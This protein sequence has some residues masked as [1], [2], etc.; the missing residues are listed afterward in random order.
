MEEFIAN[1]NVEHKPHIFAIAAQAFRAA[2]T[3]MLNGIPVSSPNQAFIISGESGSGKTESTKL[4]LQ[5]ISEASG[6]LGSASSGMHSYILSVNPLLEAFGNA[7][8]VRNDNSSR[9]GKW[10]EIH[11]KKGAT[12]KPKMVGAV[13]INYLLEKS[14]V[15]SVGPGE[16]GYHIF[17]QLCSACAK[18]PVLN[19]KYQLDHPSKF[20]FLNGSNVFSLPHLSD[21]KEFEN[22]LSAMELIKFTPEEIDGILQI[23]A[24]IL[25]AGNIVIKG[26][27]TDAGV[28]AFI[29]NEAQ[30][31]KT[32][33]ILEVP[34]EILKR[35]ILSK[36]FGIG[37]LAL[38]NLRP[39]EAIAMRNS[40][41]TGLYAK[42]FDWLVHKAN[43]QLASSELSS[44]KTQK[45]MYIGV[46]DIFGFEIFE[47]NSFEQFW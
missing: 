41:C 2:T 39:E 21:D 1:N 12:V 6:G 22:T 35:V 29:E 43:K 19:E 10:M 15:I 26:R 31:Q 13:I 36:E 34:V 45:D 32:A 3:G 8:T 5:Y 9:F 4:I 47:N 28:H 33:A 16:R 44:E 17:Y 7:K 25:H 30:L 27:E 14:R 42:L 11:F 38:I 20:N 24:A 18:D 40:L 37:S 23:I 46:L